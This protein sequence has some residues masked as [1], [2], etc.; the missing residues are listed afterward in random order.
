MYCADPDKARN[1]A[2]KLGATVATGGIVACGTALGSDAFIAQ[3]I[4][5]RCGST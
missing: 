5:Q 2:A 3:H 4:Q 1:V